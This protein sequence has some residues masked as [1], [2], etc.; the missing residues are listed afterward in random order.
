MPLI[1]LLLMFGCVGQ[2][3]FVSSFYQDQVLSSM[4]QKLD[5]LCEQVNSSKE[6][7]PAAIKDSEL[8]LDDEAFGTEK[9]K[10]VDCGCWHCERHSPFFNESMVRT[11]LV[12]VAYYN[13]QY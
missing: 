7:S 9:I 3:C 12:L 1:L 2:F 6:N 10:F 13:C 5:N 11:L 8:K 4:Q